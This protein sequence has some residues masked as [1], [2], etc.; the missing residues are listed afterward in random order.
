MKL[1]EIRIERFRGIEDQTISN[2]N[3]ALAFIGK[4]NAG[5]SAV[6]T[7]VRALWGDYAIAEKDFYKNSSDLKISASFIC[8]DDY[9]SDYFLD[10]KVGIMKIPSTAGDYGNASEGTVWENKTF[11]VF[12]T[13]R[14]DV[15]NTGLL[16][17]VSTRK[18]FFDIWL[19]AIKNKLGIKGEKLDVELTCTKSDFKRALD[20]KEVD[21]LLPNLAFISESRK[22]EEEE[23]GKNRSLTANMFNHILS[24]DSMGCASSVLCE[25]CNH[26]DCETRCFSTIFKK[27]AEELNMDELQKLVNYKA[28][29]SSTSITQSITEQFNKNYRKDFRVNIKATS[30]INKSFSLS[31]K[32]YDPALDSEIELSNVGA[33]VRSVY[34]LSLLQVYQRISAKHTIFI[35]EEPELYLHPQ[36]QKMMAKTLSD[37]SE[38]NQVFFTTHSPLMLREFSSYEIRQ[39][40]LDEDKYLTLIENANLDSIL[41]EIGYSS[42]DV[43]NTDYVIFVEGPS[44]KEILEH[45]LPKYYNVNLERISIIDTKSCSNIGY[46]ATLRFLNKTTMSKDLVII[47]DVDTETKEAVLT[48]LKNQLS[49]NMNNEYFDKINDRIYITKFSSIEGYIFSPEVLVNHNIY[50][51]IDD[52]YNDLCNKLV[53]KKPSII[54]YFKK[55]N[56]GNKERIKKFEEEYDDKVTHIRDNLEWMKCNVQGHTYFGFTYSGTISWSDYIDELPPDTFKDLLTFFDSIPYFS[57]KKK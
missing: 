7:A 32:I 51:T 40:R 13:A 15:Q 21:Y 12:R 57:S 34:I 6:L 44:D 36:L 4:N 48:T 38:H 1:V 39:V 23:S 2:I 31:T 19:N 22:F 5:K 26:T 54:K 14:E 35:I 3:N 11:S 17:D 10:S 55:H 42:Q 25:N 28:K 41:N 49:V 18:E 52:V 45:L 53:E 16:E 43:L 29:S 30:S 47:R 46:Y 33:G 9:L 8:T 37:I 50:E 27:N 24:M 56:S 20:K